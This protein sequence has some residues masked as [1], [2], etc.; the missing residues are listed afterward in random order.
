MPNGLS[1]SS[2]VRRIFRRATALAVVASSSPGRPSISSSG[3]SSS[4]SSRNGTSSSSSTSSSSAK[5]TPR[6]SAGG[7]PASAPSSSSSSSVSSGRLVDRLVDLGRLVGFLFDSSSLGVGDLGRLLPR[8]PR[9]RARW[10]GRGR[11]GCAPPLRDRTRCR[12]WGSA[13]G[14]RPGRRT[15]PGSSGKSVWRRVRDWPKDE[16]SQDGWIRKAAAPLP[17][18]GPLSKAIPLGP[19]PARGG[20]CKAHR[21]AAATLTRPPG[22]ASDGQRARARRQ[23]DLA[24]RADPGRA[25]Q[26]RDRDRGPAGGR[27]R[28]AHRRAM[29]AFGAE[30]ERLGEGRWRVEGTRRL[31]R[32]RRRRRL[33]QRRHRRAADHGRGGGLPIWPP[34]SP[35]TPRCAARPMSRVLNPLGE[36]G[37]RWI[38]RDGGRLPLTLQGGEPEAHR[39]PPAGALGPGEVGGAAGRAARRR[40]ASR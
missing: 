13:P 31:R 15:S 34:P 29:A 32:A 23:V 30:V 24:P 14:A 4:S 22:G 37:A 18:A 28:P 12:T 25:G 17:R 38:G 20:P 3:K 39:L 8:R 26:R 7:A 9:S 1:R 5:S 36:M 21:M 10:R 2:R 11:G 33:R 40:A 19:T 6:S 35:A 16:T 27:R